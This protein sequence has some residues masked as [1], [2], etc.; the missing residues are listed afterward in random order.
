MDKISLILSEIRKGKKIPNFSRGRYEIALSIFSLFAFIFVKDLYGSDYYKLLISMACFLAFNLFFNFLLKEKSEIDIRFYFISNIFNCLAIF[1]IMSYSGGKNSYLWFLNLLPVMAMS[2]SGEALYSYLL[3]FFSFSCISYFYVIDFSGDFSDYFSL[4]FKSAVMAAA[5]AFIKSGAEARKV[6]E[7]ELA[8]K[9][10]Q[11][12]MLLAETAKLSS[13]KTSQTLETE[14]TDFNAVAL[15]DLKNLISVIYMISQIIQKDETFPK[16]EAE[17]LLSAASSAAKLSKY[18]LSF[19]KEYVFSPQKIDLGNFVKETCGILEYKTR[20][21]KIKLINSVD[22]GRFFINADKLSFQRS[23][24]NLI[25]NSFLVLPEEGE[26]NIS[27]TDTGEKLI[28]N[29]YDNGPGFPAQILDGIKPYNTGRIKEG[30]T[31]L[32]LYSV[33]KEIAK[34]GGE[35]KIYN[36]KK[37]G[38]CCEIIFPKA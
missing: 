36:G 37:G 21:K 25:L 18:A 2:L 11:A 19:R 12:D 20:T 10:K 30:G 9:R 24:A 1:F 34:N 15:H 27:V 16:K 4:I 31:G 29:I 38:A 8:F 33:L 22:E 3:M 28:L 26:I 6:I 13:Q 23:L 35:F 14:K 32:G 7:A 17:K 5:S